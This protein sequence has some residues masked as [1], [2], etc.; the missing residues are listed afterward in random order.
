MILTIDVFALANKQV[1]YK[2]KHTRSTENSYGVI[3]PTAVHAPSVVRTLVNIFLRAVT[4]DVLQPS[5]S[6]AVAIDV[7]RLRSNIS[8]SNTS[9]NN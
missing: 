1:Q 2:P 5:L 8:D 7:L 4:L 6:T 9:S 3:R